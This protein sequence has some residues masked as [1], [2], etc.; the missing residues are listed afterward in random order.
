M[1][2]CGLSMRRM[3]LFA[4]RNWVMQYVQRLKYL[5]NGMTLI[6]TLMSGY[7]E[8]GYLFVLCKRKIDRDTAWEMQG[9]SDKETDREER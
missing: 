2:A 9:Q 1:A 8:G 6:N 4:T 5:V 7:S 3:E